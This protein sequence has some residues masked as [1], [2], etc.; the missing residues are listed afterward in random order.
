[1]QLGIIGLP[2]SGKTTIFNALTQSELP[3]GELMGGERFEVHTAVV[4]VP[5]ARL[6]SVAEVFQPKRITPAKVTYADI[7]G[8]GGQR[9]AEGLPGPLVNQLE[10]MDGLLVVLRAFEDENVPHPLGG[11]SPERDWQAL[12]E[13]L[14]L[15]DLLMVE[16][17]R[18]KLEEEWGKGDGPAA[19]GT[20][21]VQEPLVILER[22][23]A[24]LRNA[25]VLGQPN[26]QVLIG[27]PYET[28]RMGSL[29]GAFRHHGSRRVTHVAH[30]IFTQNRPVCHYRADPIE[31]YIVRREHRND[32]GLCH[33]G[34]HIYL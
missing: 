28:G 12:N 14:I 30:D 7:A 26:R 4:E 23:L 1:M 8:L 32:T 9:G 20:G 3:T 19:L 11:I 27:D 21:G 5:D 22:V 34:T 6:L 25:R 24:R 17:R 29:F 13:E 33:G 10:Q 2:A 18:A 31:R 16:R 15:H